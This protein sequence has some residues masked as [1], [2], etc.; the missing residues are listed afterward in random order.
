[1]RCGSSGDE[2][3][4]KM[5]ACVQCGEAYHVF[6]IEGSLELTM[7]ALEQGWRCIK[8]KVCIWRLRACERRHGVTHPPWQAGL[9]DVP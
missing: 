5:V 2:K 1:M 7:H 4:E 8:C 9:R 6:C 3:D